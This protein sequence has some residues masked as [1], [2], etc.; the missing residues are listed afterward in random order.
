MEISHQTREASADLTDG[1][2][3]RDQAGEFGY[4]SIADNSIFQLCDLG[5]IRLKQ[6]LGRG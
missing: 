6:L 1:D 2:L 5:A 4:Y 3:T